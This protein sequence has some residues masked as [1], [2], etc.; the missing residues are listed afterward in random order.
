MTSEAWRRVE[1]LYFEASALAPSDRAS[2]LDHACAGQLELRSEVESL[3]EADLVSGD[4]LELPPSQLAADVLQKRPSESEFIG[5]YRIL[6][7]L[8]EGGMGTVYKAE[9]KNPQRIVALKMIRLAM[10][11]VTVRRRFELESE[12]LGRLQHPGIAQI[13]DAG[14]SGN[15]AGAQPY[16]A[17]EFIHGRPLLA[18]AAEPSPGTTALTS[19]GRLELM[20]KVCDAVNHAHQR[21]ILHRDLKPG[22]ILV[23]ESGQPKVVD[24]GVACILDSDSQATRQTDLGQLIGTLDYMSPEQTLGDP[25]DMDVRSDIYSLGVILYELL[26]GKLPYETKQLALPELVRVIRE[27][28]PEPLSA[29][30]RGYRG[31]I[32]TIVEKA[33]EK[34]KER[35]YAS[36]AEL[37][38]DIRRHLADEPILAMPASAAYRA[39]KFSRRYRTGLVS[40]GL[41]ILLILGFGIVMA[42]L[43][44]KTARERDVAQTEHARAD[45]VVDFLQN[46]VLAQANGGTQTGPTRN[47]DLKVRE[48][49]DRAAVR[50]QGKFEQQPLVEASIRETIGETYSLM[51]I[52][53]SAV[54][55]IERALDIRRRILGEAHPDTITSMIKLGETYRANGM[56]A[57]G[58]PLLR[59]ALETGTRA[60]GE[61]HPIVLMA[62]TELAGT[63]VALGKPMQAEELYR[64]VLEIRRRT[65]GSANPD[66]IGA[67]NDMAVVYGTQGKSREAEELYLQAIAAGSAL[68]PGTTAA[69]D[70]TLEPMSNLGNLYVRQGKY[71]EA[72]PY[73]KK[74]LDVARRTLNEE[75]PFELFCIDSLGALYRDEGRFAEA[76]AL[77]EQS[78]KVRRHVL[79]EDNRGTLNDVS[80]LG[81][82]YCTA[83]KWGEG[84]RMLLQAVTAE[85][86]LLSDQDRFTVRSMSNLGLCYLRQNKLAEAEPWAATVATI[87]RRQFGVSNPATAD[88]IAVLADIKLRRGLISEADS[89]IKDACAIPSQDWHGF[90]CRSLLGASLAAQKS[91]QLAEPL[92][93]SGYRGMLQSQDNMPAGRTMHV[94]N[95]RA[96]LLRLYEDW[97]RPEMAA[98]WK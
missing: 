13:Y 74:A 91:F 2:F 85:R 36:A 15:G 51:G 63:Y 69:A 92:L 65:Q 1:S 68:K 90:Y 18:Y 75:H 53:P 24:F 37:A 52:Q 98:P 44:A 16:F 67:M 56:G 96:Q 23:D 60:L 42:M 29:I 22:N 97:G 12:A 26:A 83:G 84:E 30:Q 32:E 5:P 71:N 59:K 80:Y 11:S 9:Q 93:V 78:L 10:M 27:D 95:A 79:G 57:H 4:F 19:R 31:D 58:E 70:P 8:G 61:A 87:W 76:E 38:D 39:A 25:L 33:L 55:Q 3:L 14:T 28:D 48:A 49:L 17:M 86:R 88:A 45:A 43:A 40:V 72:E 62:S 47:P 46:D 20:A 34:D 94:T 50:I 7:V 35:R 21:G 41:F 89:L 77:F 64:K 73:L 54:V 82:L 81:D 6:G 66:T